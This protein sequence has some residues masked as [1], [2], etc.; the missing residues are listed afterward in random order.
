MEAWIKQTSF[1]DYQTIFWKTD[2]HNRIHMLHFQVGDNQNFPANAGRLYSCLNRT[3]GGSGPCDFEEIAP[4]TV[5]L[6]EWHY[7]AWTYDE[8]VGRLWD[9]SVEVFSAPFTDAWL[10]NDIDLLIGQHQELP[11]ANFQ[12][13]IDEARIYRGALTQDEIIR[14]MNLVPEPSTF[15]LLA[16]GILGIQFSRNRENS[17]LSSASFC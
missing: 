1:T 3:A 6:N 10:G 15:F 14:D 16:L 17:S 11:F 8:S 9:N 12:G 4:R 5:G 7:V 2:R 13:L